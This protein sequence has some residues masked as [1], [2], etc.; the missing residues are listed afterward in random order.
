MKINFSLNHL[1]EMVRDFSHRKA[2]IISLFS[3]GIVLEIKGIK[4]AITVTTYKS[5]VLTIKSETK[6]I[7]VQV[8]RLFA[9]RKI[10]KKIRK[11]LKHYRLENY[12][13]FSGKYCRIKIDELINPWLQ[14]VYGGPLESISVSERG[15]EVGI[16]Y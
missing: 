1:Q 13:E 15:L 14:A 3:G 5:G 7:F 2:R 10:K 4:A 11:K 8:A 6:N 16:R 9:S 12:F